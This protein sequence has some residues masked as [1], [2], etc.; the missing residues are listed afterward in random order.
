MRECAW[1]G[2]RILAVVV[3]AVPVLVLV[4]VYG[5]DGLGGLLPALSRLGR[6]HLAVGRLGVA[7]GGW[8]ASVRAQCLV[9]GELS[10]TG[11]VWEGRRARCRSAGSSIDVARR[12]LVDATSCARSPASD[13]GLGRKFWKELLILADPT[14]PHSTATPLQEKV[15]ARVQHWERVCLLFLY[16]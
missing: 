11:A 14:T 15:T 2:G 7:Q 1:R 8:G 10:G 5:L 12:V 13:P 6:G 16:Q 4:L 9:G 3:L